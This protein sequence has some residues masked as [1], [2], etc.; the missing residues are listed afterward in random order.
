MKNHLLFPIKA[1]NSL[2]IIFYEISQ[3]KTL[4]EHIKNA[5]Y[6]FFSHWENTLYPVK[7]NKNKQKIKPINEFFYFLG[8]EKSNNN[9]VNQYDK[10]Y[11]KNLEKKIS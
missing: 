6:N 11:K 8:N 3:N 10:L 7:I 9:Q 1:F 2:F 5:I 4:K